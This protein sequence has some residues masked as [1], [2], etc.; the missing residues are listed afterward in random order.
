M[1]GRLPGVILIIVNTFQF[2]TR[3][4]DSLATEFLSIEGSKICQ[5]AS[6]ILQC[7]SANRSRN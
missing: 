6:K 5:L 4:Q 7:L 1:W 2:I 3:G